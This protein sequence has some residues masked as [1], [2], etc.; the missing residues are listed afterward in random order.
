MGGNEKINRFRWIDNLKLVAAW[1]IVLGHLMNALAVG[2]KHEFFAL[3]KMINF[4]L[5]SGILNGEFWVVLF[6]M[7]SGYLLSRKKITSLE[8]FFF[9]VVQRYFRFVA[10][11]FLQTYL[12]MQYIV[13]LVTIL[14]SAEGY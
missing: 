5:L 14:Q 7:I 8:N 6:C 2:E 13:Q 3:S 4:Y 12:L 1:G 11:L 9:S 10:P